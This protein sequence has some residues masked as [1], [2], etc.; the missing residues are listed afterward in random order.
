MKKVATLL[1]GLLL[2]PLVALSS[3]VHRASLHLK[4]GTLTP[5]LNVGTEGHHTSN[6]VA[7]VAEGDLEAGQ[8]VRF[9]LPHDGHDRR[10]V[11]YDG[12]GVP[13]GITTACA[14]SGHSVPI[15]LLGVN[16]GT[17]LAYIDPDATTEVKTSRL[18]DSVN[19]SGIPRCR[20]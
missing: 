2:I 17:T 12:V 11:A 18:A 9:Y 10:V 4:H 7:Y 8:L 1:L 3:A 13:I 19:K 20:G 5:A 14:K 15:F 6:P 16:G